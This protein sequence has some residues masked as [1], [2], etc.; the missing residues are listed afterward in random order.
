M[1]IFNLEDSLVLEV[2]C[3]WSWDVCVNYGLGSTFKR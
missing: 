3:Y 1:I 2:P